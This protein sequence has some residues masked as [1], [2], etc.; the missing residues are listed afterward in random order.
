MLKKDKSS[1][2]H[3]TNLTWGRFSF[4]RKS[5]WIIAFGK[6]QASTLH[7]RLWGRSNEDISQETHCLK[8]EKFDFQNVKTVH[9]S[10]VFLILTHFFTTLTTFPFVN[11]IIL[12]MIR[13]KN[14]ME[15]FPD[16]HKI[17]EIVNLQGSKTFSKYFRF[18]SF[19]FSWVGLSRHQ[20]F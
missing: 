13:P 10:R 8:F 16:S 3:G 20:K 14:I 4:V 5:K 6:I 11:W 18:Q 1:V 7:V 9:K 12:Y 17:K 19:F 15:L 2:R